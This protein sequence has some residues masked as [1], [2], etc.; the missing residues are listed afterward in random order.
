MKRIILLVSFM[1]CCG[2]AVAQGWFE[3]GTG[4]NALNAD[5]YIL[6]ICSDT[7]GDMYA[8]GQFTDSSSVIHGKRYVAKWDNS[9]HQWSELGTGANRLNANDMICSI[10]SDKYNNIYAAGAFTDSSVSTLSVG[11]SFVTKWDGTKWNKLGVGNNTMNAYTPGL[12]NS[13][14][15]DKNDNIYAAG[16]FTDS[17]YNLYV[18]KWNGTAWSNLMGLNANYNII[19]ICAD[20]SSNI[21]AAG[22]F[23]DTNGFPYVAKWENSTNT[24]HQ[25]GSGLDTARFSYIS[26]IL[27]DKNAF[28][29][30]AVNI[31]S[32]STWTSEI[33]K[34]DGFGWNQLGHLDA[35]NSTYTLCLGDSGVIYAAGDFT[36]INGKR[37]V[38]K[39]NPLT[40][41]WN[42]VGT[43]TEALN[44][45][46]NIGTLCTDS[47]S[48]I[49]A[50]GNFTDSISPTNNH[51]AIME[52]GVSNLVVPSIQS[53]YDIAVYPNPAKV[54]INV[55]FNPSTKN[56][57]FKYYLY[58]CIGQMCKNGYLME[59]NKAIIDVS[60]LPFGTYGLSIENMFFKILKLN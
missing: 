16:N 55:Q 13:L 21:Y 40:G 7:N 48:H 38:A 5:A 20:D 50:G 8:A 24:W 17:H 22:N 60:E 26:K 59:N 51:W 42:E 27:V 58:N 30:A 33:F 31:E 14:C 12:I 28:V 37:Y 11:Y 6:S 35:N 10:I 44:A 3:L 23:T 41:L 18:A 34:W 1:A 45:N 4:A 2:C 46:G 36:N 29:F 15:I 53:D 47:L 43:G 39:Y 19:S 56:R 9:L 32:G 57:Q 52:Y 54:E 25:L 49:F